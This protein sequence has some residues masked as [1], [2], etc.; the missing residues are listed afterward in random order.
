MRPPRQTSRVERLKAKV[1]PLLTQVTV[2]CQAL[3]PHGSVFVVDGSNRLSN[4][5]SLYLPIVSQIVSLSLNRL[6][7]CLSLSLPIVPQIL[8]LSPSRL[9]HSLSLSLSLC[10][11]QSWSG[12]H[13]RLTQIV[14]HFT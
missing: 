7:N 5:L 10:W 1:E 9:S 6:S 4:C 13:Q 14:S 8:S 3:P 11:A 12:A 2:D